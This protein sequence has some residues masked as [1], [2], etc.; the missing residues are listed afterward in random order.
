MRAYDECNVIVQLQDVALCDTIG[1]D[2]AAKCSKCQN[3]SM[4]NQGR[5]INL[6]FVSYTVS[7]GYM[8]E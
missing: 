6:F 8:Y 3:L 1:R 4:F 5:F 7:E 2:L